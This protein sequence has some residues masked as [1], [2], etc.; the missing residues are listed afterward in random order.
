MPLLFSDPSASPDFHPIF[1]I[2]ALAFALP[3]EVPSSSAPSPT[4]SPV[5]GPT[6]IPP[7]PLEG[8]KDLV[9]RATSVLQKITL[10]TLF[11][12]RMKAASSN[13]VDFDVL[14][15]TRHRVLPFP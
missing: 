5:R 3:L 6:L 2:I 9:C 8:F 10:R 13:P 7:P 15:T 12:D 11:S 14:V 1:S 4:F